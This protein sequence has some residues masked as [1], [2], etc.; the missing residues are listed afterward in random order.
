[1]PYHFDGYYWMGRK[2]RSNSTWDSRRRGEVSRLLTLLFRNSLDHFGPQRWWPGETREEVIIGAVLTQNTSWSNVERAL[3]ELRR[4][5]PLTLRAVT[6]IPSDHLARHIR[7]VGYFSLKARRLQSVARWFVER[8]DPVGR[9]RKKGALPNRVPGARGKGGNPKRRVHADTEM[10]KAPPRFVEDCDLMVPPRRRFSENGDSVDLTPLIGLRG[11]AL[12]ALRQEILGI[13]GVG[14]ETADS[15]LLYA[16]EGAT[17]VVDA[18]TM[19]IGVR[20]GLFPAGTAYEEVKLIFEGILGRDADL[21]NEY[22]AQIVALG[23]YFCKT[24]NPLCER[25][26]LGAKEC[27]AF[28]RHHGDL[29]AASRAR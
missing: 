2:N 26:P 10:S 15:I 5:I 19:R 8:C 4:E 13:H 11:A 20:H 12:E 28:A 14:P 1:M 27:F 9:K 21:F 7:P 3:K 6:E 29:A 16:L 25:C 24:R 17:F 23:K 22:H 18:Y